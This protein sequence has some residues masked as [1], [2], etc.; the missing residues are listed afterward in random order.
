[1]RILKTL[2]KL[3]FGALFVFAGVLHFVS[4][5]FFMRIMPPYLPW[6]LEIVYLSG[7]IE[8]V[9]GV[10]LWIP[11][12]TRL[13]AWGLIALLIAVFP[14]NIY[15]YQNQD[16]LFRE[17]SPNLHLVRLLLQGGMILWAYCYTAPGPAPE[18]PAGA[19]ANT[20]A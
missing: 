11:R 5:D 18:T 14:A 13:A 20:T 3:L 2:S 6:H 15:V 8:I 12:Y 7:V 16:T 10:L 17:M 9:L 19:S 1:M 4:V